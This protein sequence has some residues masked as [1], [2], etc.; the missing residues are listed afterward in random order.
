[1]RYNQSGSLLRTKD[2]CNSESQA[3]NC[4]KGENS[5]LLEEIMIGRGKVGR[6]SP[7]ASRYPRHRRRHELIQIAVG[8]RGQL[9]RAEADVVERLVVHAVGLV[10]VLHQLADRERRVVRLDDS[11]RDLG[12]RHHRERRDD[13]VRILLADL[14]GYQ[15]SHARARPAAQR[16]CHLK[17]FTSALYFFAIKARLS[18]CNAGEYIYRNNGWVTI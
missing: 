14:R 9:E 2:N 5:R 10:G 4:Q 16:V 18:L 6:R 17:A 11:V 3:G 15:G 8:G 1:M 13:A 7:E 12:R